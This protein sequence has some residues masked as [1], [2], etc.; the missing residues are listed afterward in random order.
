[1][2]FFIHTKAFLVS[3]SIHPV[4]TAAELGN[5][6]VL[7]AT[8]KAHPNKLNQYKQAMSPLHGAYTHKH[9][10]C[11][12]LLLESGANASPRLGFDRQWTLLHTVSYKSDSTTIR[13]LLLYGANPQLKDSQELTPFDL[14]P[15]NSMARRY[16]QETRQLYIK[17]ENNKRLAKQAIS[18]NQRENAAIYLSKIAECWQSAADSETHPF[19]RQFYYYK[20]LEKAKQ[21][22]QQQPSTKIVSLTDKLSS[23]IQPYD[24]KSTMYNKLSVFF[25]K[26]FLENVCS[27]AC[28]EKES[29]NQQIY[30]PAPPS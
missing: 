25:D 17:L 24:R 22:L 15:V 16:L 20:A 12:L 23:Y 18:H 6:D 8:I 14:A 1:M 26:N 19:L 5:L 9:Y 21:A 27:K 29:L 28:V 13:L 30:S 11:M 7:N 2:R 4:F 10:D 3:L